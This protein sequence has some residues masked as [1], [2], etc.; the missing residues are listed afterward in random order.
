MLLMSWSLNKNLFL[1]E[2][3]R[4]EGELWQSDGDK[5]ELD[6]DLD[7][8]VMGDGGVEVGVMAG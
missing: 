7:D 1:Q 8:D 2:L 6:D 3:T 5:D 4:R